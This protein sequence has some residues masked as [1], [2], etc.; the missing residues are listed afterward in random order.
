MERA[1]KVKPVDKSPDVPT[2]VKTNPN[3]PDTYSNDESWTQ[4]EK[5]DLSFLLNL[6]DGV[7]EIPGRIVI[8]TSNFPEKLDHALI[9]PGRID[10][11][12]NFTKCSHQ[13]MIEMMEFF[14]DIVLTNEEKQ[15]IMRTNEYVI[16][17]A[18]MSKIMFENFS[19]HAGAIQKLGKIVVPIKIEGLPIEVQTTEK[20]HIEVETIDKAIFQPMVDEI[21]KKKQNKLYESSPEVIQMRLDDQSR[22]DANAN[23]FTDKIDTVSD[24]N[25]VV[26]TP[27]FPDDNRIDRMNDRKQQL[28]EC[29]TF[30]DGMNANWLTAQGNENFTPPHSTTVVL[31]YESA[32][33][34][35]QFSSFE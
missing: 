23:S 9:R 30:T 34:T 6:L 33:Q 16:S 10:V 29:A 17:P 11:I 27:T 14:Y 7:L 18:E 15:A 4:A 2:S 3:K 1:A 19:N 20:V 32:S 13:T 26:K 25:S 24:P 8:M 31:P 5:I 28:S 21:E 12:A 35:N 22:S